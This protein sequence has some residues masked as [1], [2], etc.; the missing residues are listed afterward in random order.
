MSTNNATNSTQPRPATREYVDGLKKAYAEMPIFPLSLM[1]DNPCFRDGG[2]DYTLEPY[3]DELRAFEQEINAN[4]QKQQQN[5]L[6]GLF[7]KLGSHLRHATAARELTEPMKAGVRVI[8]PVLD[9]IEPDTTTKVS[10]TCAVLQIKETTYQVRLAFVADREKWTD[11]GVLKITQNG[12]VTYQEADDVKVGN[13]P[14][15]YP[16]C[17]K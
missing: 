3:L 10:V 6:Q 12:Q 2:V 16:G 9:E 8:L 17:D 11:P 7:D 13:G 5:P 15:Y 14:D 4:K 1:I